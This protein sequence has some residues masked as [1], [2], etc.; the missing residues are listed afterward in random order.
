V[1]K[2]HAGAAIVVVIAA[3]ALLQ[4]WQRWLHPIIDTGRDLY[5]P[6][7]LARGAKL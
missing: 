1:I 2:R 4:S 6:E 7:Q 5:I 3:V